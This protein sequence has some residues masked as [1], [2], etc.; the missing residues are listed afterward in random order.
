[1][2][3]KILNITPGSEYNNSP[4]KKRLW[5]FSNSKTLSNH[6]SNDSVSF[7][8]AWKFLRNLNWN[9]SNLK[10]HADENFE[11]HFFVKNIEFRIRVD[12]NE[13]YRKPFQLSI[14]QKRN[15]SESAKQISVTVEKDV[16]NYSNELHIPEFKAI[17]TFLNRIWNLQIS[18]ELS[19]DEFNLNDLLDEIF[20]E[21]DEE[22][23]F[24]IQSVIKLGEKLFYKSY[25][26]IPKKK[27]ELSSLKVKRIK[28]TDAEIH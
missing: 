9:L 13:L 6:D 26:I 23:N 5:G 25:P 12:F 28:I 1:M 14:L 11:L 22:I 21:A 15:F 18:N 17:E 4:A 24:L 27:D 19:D 8:S 16:R 10:L 2:L 20:D 7:S 3:D